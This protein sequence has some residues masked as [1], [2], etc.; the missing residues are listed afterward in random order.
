MNRCSECGREID[1]SCEGPTEDQYFICQTCIQKVTVS[2][3]A[4]IVPLL[5][6]VY[7]KITVSLEEH[8]WRWLQQHPREKASWIL[9]EAI[10][11]KIS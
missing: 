2:P 11:A 5:K 7:H 3:G 6:P 10:E 4:V 8:Q 9:R 1:S